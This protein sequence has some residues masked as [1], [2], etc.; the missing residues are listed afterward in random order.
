MC[1]ITSITG[2]KYFLI[3][4]ALVTLFEKRN[5]IIV[6]SGLENRINGRGDP[7]R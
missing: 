6:T 5:V 1:I 2:I 4:S 7:L 3:I